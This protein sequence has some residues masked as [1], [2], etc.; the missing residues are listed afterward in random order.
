MAGK[1]IERELPAWALPTAVVIGALLLVLVGWKAVTGGIES[2]GP[3]IKVH[4]GQY[5]LRAEVAKMRTAQQPQQQ[6]GN[7]K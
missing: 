5:D 1:G 7:L 6:M 2:A 3:A 4:A